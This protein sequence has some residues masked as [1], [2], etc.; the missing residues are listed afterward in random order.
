[1][2]IFKK[3][4]Q[5]YTEVIF[6]HIC[7]CCGSSTNSDENSICSLCRGKR[8]ET[9]GS[10]KKE[11]LPQSAAFVHTMWFFDKDSYLQDLLHKLKYHFMRGVGIE[12]GY[13]LGKDFLH[14][15]SKV[16]LKSIDDL[17]PVIIP[18]PLHVKKRRKRGYNQ[19]RALAEG[20]SR[21]TGWNIISKGAIKRTRNTKTQ[22]GLTSEQRSKNLKGAF[23]VTEPKSVLNRKCVLV[24]DVFTTG[25]TTFELANTLFEVTKIPSGILT[26]ARA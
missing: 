20:V 26:V 7:V 10:A 11:I 2:E 6:P 13:L 5:S 25:A 16:E 21:S 1:M 12:L 22:T 8:F 19:A 17:N 3:I 9:A 24:D 4:Y 14:Q 15:H 18:V 23:Q